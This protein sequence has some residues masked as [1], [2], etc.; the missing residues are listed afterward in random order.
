MRKNKDRWLQVS[1]KMRRSYILR[2][3]ALPF[4]K[5]ALDIRRRARLI[6]QG[7]AQ[8]I[9]KQMV[10]KSIPGPISTT[11]KTSKI[12]WWKR[13]IKA[14]IQWWNKPRAQWNI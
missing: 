4:R 2:K 5:W 11:I 6:A 9:S 12:S 13:V 14:L 1:D 8:P 7:R 3:Q 10:D